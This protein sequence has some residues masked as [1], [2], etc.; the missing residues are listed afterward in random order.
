MVDQAP[1]EL[2]LAPRLTIGI[3]DQC[4]ARRAVQ[5]ALHGAHELLVPEVGEA[6]HE[7]ADDGR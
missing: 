3:G 2:E 6:P 4:A 1:G 7:Q 5:L